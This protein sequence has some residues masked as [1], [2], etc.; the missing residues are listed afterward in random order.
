MLYVFVITAVLALAGIGLFWFFR[1]ERQRGPIHASPPPVVFI[2]RHLPDAPEPLPPSL[3]AR[4]AVST[5]PPTGPLPASAFAPPGE[6]RPQPVAHPAPSAVPQPVSQ[7]GPQLVELPV[8]LPVARTMFVGADGASRADDVREPLARE[9]LDDLGA[10]PQR[11][12]RRGP[13]RLADAPRLA[14]EPELEPVPLSATGTL[15]MLP[16]RFEVVEGHP[17]D[18]EIRFVA[19]PG[20]A[21]QRFT[22]GRGEGPPGHHVRLQGLTVSRLHAALSFRG[23][24]WTIENLSTT[25]PLRVNGREMSAEQA[26]ALLADGDIVELGEVV[27]RFR[28]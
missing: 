27:L 16:G 2:P 20:V 7:A 6:P 10:R 9:R 22:M 24:T 23:G 13:T 17:T 1:R 28:A 26:A 14:E 5:T 15:R 3:A 21:D 11:R 25:N 4:P 19:E 8:E 18:R 12:R